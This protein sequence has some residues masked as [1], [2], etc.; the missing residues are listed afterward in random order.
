MAMVDLDAKRFEAALSRLRQ[1]ADW[2]KKALAANP[3]NVQYHQFL[4]NHY[5]NMIDAFSGLG[6]VSGAA[7]AQQLLE[8]QQASDPQYAA[9]DARLAAVM[10][11]EPPQDNAERL[12]LA[13]RA[14]ATRRFASSAR[15][16]AELLRANPQ[17]AD[18][19]QAL[20]RYNA[21]C[22]AA[23][24]A[25]GRGKDDSK[26]DD[27]ARAK[28]RQQAFDWLKTEL[29][30][31]SKLVETANPQQSASITRTLQHWQ[32]DTDLA[33]I[34]DAEALAK[35]PEAERK[36]WESLWADVESL[37]KRAQAQAP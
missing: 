3:R 16:W 36:E 10:R 19:R 23:L 26:S 22:A 37:L 34:R 25:A 13:Q 30:V 14:H 32:E 6:D 33:S 7:E 1:A 17:L 15:L 11:G 35:L 29:R 31:W 20:H 24:A 5:A 18:D 21:A 28:L 4:T 8:E 2:Q 9:L 27:T 12:A